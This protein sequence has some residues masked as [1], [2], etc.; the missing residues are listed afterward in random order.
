MFDKWLDRCIFYHPLTHDTKI[1][2][3]QWLHFNLLLSLLQ[4]IRGSSGWENQQPIAFKEMQ[5]KQ[6][7]K[8]ASE[9]V[10]GLCSRGLLFSRRYRGWVEIRSEHVKPSSRAWV[11]TWDAQASGVGPAALRGSEHAD[12]LQKGVAR[13]RREVTKAKKMGSFKEYR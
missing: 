3:P 9:I 11:W 10:A 13:G 5:Q 12:F 6:K 1:N 7:S 4:G 2:K 8:T